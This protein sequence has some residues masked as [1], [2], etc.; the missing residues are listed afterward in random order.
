MTG[1]EQRPIC[2]GVNFR[3]IRDGRFKT[4]RM[5]VHFMLPLEKKTASANAILPF[6][7]T[8]ASRKYPDFTKLNEHL[9]DLYGAVLDADVQT[10]GDVQILSVSASGIADRY[11]LRGENIS[12]DLSDLLC[13]VLFD[14]LLK[15][16]QFP[17]DGFSQSKRQMIEL[18]DSEF[19]DKRLYALRRCREI[20]CSEEPCGVGRFGAKEDIR[21]LERS[22]LT[23]VWDNLIRRARAEVMVLGDCDPEPVYRRFSEAFCRLGRASAVSCPTKV[24]KSA[25]TVRQ[26]V[27]RQDVAQSKLVMGFRTETAE[28]DKD[29]PAVKLMSVLYGGTPS[30]KLF[31]NVREKLSLCYYCSS[32]YDPVKGI[33]AVQS[34][35]EQKNAG[36][37]KD[38]ILAQL[39]LVK[40]GG[41]TEEELK[42]ARMSLCNSYRTISDS[43]DGLEAWYLSKTFSDPLRRPEQEA[44][45]I[46]AVSRE[47]V[48]QAANRVTLDTVYCLT[49]NEVE[50]Q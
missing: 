37:A 13:S 4:V 46:Q 15:D 41:F 32:L 38:E 3:A 24:V 39:D 31:L 25:D 20:M 34:G 21:S 16:G 43:L 27:E 2:D 8:R 5:S 22:S 14:P 17:E 12:S 45:R 28:P 47:D 23:S 36:R 7:L 44:A 33:L 42:A 48:V 26:T 6:L 29:V 9:A 1:I 19:N 40:K 18:T 11:A 49:G 10:L 50:K 30:S 35:V